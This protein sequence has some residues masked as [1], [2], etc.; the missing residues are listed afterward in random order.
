MSYIR[1]YDLQDFHE[2]NDYHP[3]ESDHYDSDHYASDYDDIYE[4]VSDEEDGEIDQIA[5]LN[6]TFLDSEKRSGMYIVGMCENSTSLYCSG[7]ISSIFFKFSYDN[8]NKYLFYH[9]IFMVDQ[10]KINIIQLIINK[11]DFYLSSIAIQKTIW[12][13]LIQRHWKKV[14]KNKND[15]IKKRGS[16]YNQLSFE[17][18]GKYKKGC[19]IFKGLKGLLN[20]YAK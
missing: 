6:S 1:S 15:I 11:E 14:Y 7:I 12:I 13:K 2:E 19:N 10:P 20:C 3:N 9:N 18:T 4:N 8:I 17:T 16:L 5:D